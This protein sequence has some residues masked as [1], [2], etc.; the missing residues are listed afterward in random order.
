LK[1][2]IEWC[3]NMAINEGNIGAITGTSYQVTLAN[4]LPSDAQV[5]DI[6][7]S[8]GWLP[9]K[10]ELYNNIYKDNRARGQLLTIN[11]VVAENNTYDHQTGAAILIVPDCNYW[12]QSDTTSNMILR[13]NTFNNVNYAMATEK[14]DIAI[15]VQLANGLLTTGQ[16]NSNITI[17]NNKFIQTQGENAIVAYAIDGLAISGNTI[18]YEPKPAS[19]FL[20][21]NNINENV[22]NNQCSYGG[23]TQTC[24]EVH[25]VILVEFL[26][27]SL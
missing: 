18:Q 7:G 15:Y 17:E 26:V 1:G 11:N 3:E 2:N 24:I 22:N 27:L 20:L 5:N 10:V 4:P 8:P 19:T 16:V 14:G 25:H 12:L 6:I 13:G 9:S 23:S 21:S